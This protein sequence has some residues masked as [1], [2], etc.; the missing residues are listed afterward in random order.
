MCEFVLPGA[1]KDETAQRNDPARVDPTLRLTAT[2][3]L[4]SQTLLLGKQVTTVKRR[5]ELVTTLA[6]RSITGYQFSFN[7]LFLETFATR[8]KQQER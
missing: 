4:T 1:Q 8:N 3:P 5:V 2:S 7:A 6:L